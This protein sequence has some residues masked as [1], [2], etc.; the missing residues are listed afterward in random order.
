MHVKANN[1]EEHLSSEDLA[2]YKQQF[3]EA[4]EQDNTIEIK[5]RTSCLQTFSRWFLTIADNAKI[6]E[7]KELKKLFKVED[8]RF[9]EAADRGAHP[10]LACFASSSPQ[11]VQTDQDFE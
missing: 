4:Q 2:C 10:K 7:P 8:L 1:P 3:E 6:V 11:S 9:R 5:F